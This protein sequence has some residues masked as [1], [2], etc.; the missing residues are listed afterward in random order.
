MTAPKR[1]SDAESRR[2]PEMKKAKVSADA[3]QPSED[4]KQNAGPAQPATSSGQ[5]PLEKT[6]SK[7]KSTLTPGRRGPTSADKEHKRMKRLLRN[8]V[9]AQQARER[10]KVYMSDLE[11]R[12]KELEERNAELE[13][14]VSTLQREN[15]M[16]RQIVKNT[17]LKKNGGSP[18][19]S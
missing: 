7:Q 12:S 6:S 14:K 5:A 8:R 17:T 18:D 1:D 13:E 19:A 4:A 10:K 3:A 15:F 11:G 2:V 16:L 9:S